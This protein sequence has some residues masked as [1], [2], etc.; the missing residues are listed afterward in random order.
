M[1]WKEFG[2]VEVARLC[3]VQMKNDGIGAREIKALCPFCGDKHYHLYLNTV[4]NQWNCFR[5]GAR[6][7]DV[8]L[9]ARVNCMTNREAANE[10]SRCLG[11]TEPRIIKPVNS[12]PMKPLI[13]R[14]NVYYDLL[15]MLCL[16]GMHYQDLTDRGLS[17]GNIRQFMYKSIPENEYERRE[18]IK[19]LSAKYDLSGIPGFYRKFGEWKMYSPNCGGYYIPVCD[20]DGYIQGMQI[21]LDNADKRFRW[22]STNEYPEGTGVS[23]WVHVVGDISSDTAYLTEGALKA[24]VASTLSGGKLFMAVPGV[25]AINCLI[26][27]LSQLNIKKVYEV[28]DM[29][30]Q[31][32]IHVRNALIKI[33]SIL[34]ERGIEVQ[35]CTW[36]PWYKG[37]DDY[38]LYKK[39][40][41]KAT[42][43]E[44][45]AA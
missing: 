18:V 38:C 31:V 14:H 28:F 20:K 10:L 25:N 13:E 32:N 39:K 41:Y 35:T 30:K 29:D 4:K 45:Q 16:S 37:I 8:S 43:Y 21:R 15:R 26:D 36:N 42:A 7:N 27:A 2:V 11:N 40:S 9:Y 6:G 34:T 33:K 23:S 22:F 3:G 17:F 24:D 19:K 5:C 44:K 12:T 1:E